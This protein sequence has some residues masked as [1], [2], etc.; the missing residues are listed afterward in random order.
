MCAAWPAAVGGR[1]DDDTA[2]SAAAALD[3][4]GDDGG[5]GAA[6]EQPRNTTSSCEMGTSTKNRK[7]DET[8]QEF[9]TVHR[10][11]PVICPA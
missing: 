1:G 6:G 8:Y 4:A 9:S 7:N 5:G 11:N 10:G 2:A 3:V